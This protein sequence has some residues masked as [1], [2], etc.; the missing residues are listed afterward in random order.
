MLRSWAGLTCSWVLVK[1]GAPTGVWE[2]YHSAMK[3][4]W[5]LADKSPFCLAVLLPSPW[6][7]APRAAPR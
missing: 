1:Q 4:V 2:R 6:D 7:V 5:G 3:Y